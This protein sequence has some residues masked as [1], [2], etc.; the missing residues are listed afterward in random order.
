M[1][2][3]RDVLFSPKFKSRTW[4]VNALSKTFDKDGISIVAIP[5]PKIPFKDEAYR[6]FYEIAR[7]C[8]APLVTD[9]VKNYPKDEIVMTVAEYYEQLIS[10]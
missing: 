10:E 8:R 6:K 7:F 1:A 4:Q 3:Y 2:E 5:L 9:N